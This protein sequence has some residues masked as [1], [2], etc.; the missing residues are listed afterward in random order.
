VKARSKEKL[1]YY[2]SS[3]QHDAFRLALRSDVHMHLSWKYLNYVLSFG[4]GKS[5]TTTVQVLRVKLV[6]FISL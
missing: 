4:E 1:Y 6:I 5:E 3:G 2:T